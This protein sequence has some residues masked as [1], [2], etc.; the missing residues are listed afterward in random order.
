MLIFNCNGKENGKRTR[1]SPD[2]INFVGEWKVGK[3]HGQGTDTFADGSKKSDRD[4]YNDEETKKE[5][6]NVKKG[7]AADK[8]GKKTLEDYLNEGFSQVEAEQMYLNQ[9]TTGRVDE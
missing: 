8:K 6:L 2:G 5:T 7:S 1:T 4:K 9:A 3:E